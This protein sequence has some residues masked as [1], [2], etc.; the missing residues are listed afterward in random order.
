MKIYYSEW[1]RC[2][3]NEEGTG[4]SFLHSS[5]WSVWLSAKSAKIILVPFSCRYYLFA[6]WQ[7]V[8]KPIKNQN[9]RAWSWVIIH[10]FKTWKE[11]GGQLSACKTP[12]QRLPISTEDQSDVAWEAT[13]N[14]QRGLWGDRNVKADDS[15]SFH[16]TLRKQEFYTRWQSPR[17][18]SMH[19]YTM[20]FSQDLWDQDLF[21]QIDFFG[22]GGGVFV[23]NFHFLVIRIFPCHV[24]MQLQQ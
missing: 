23:F 24:R 12:R 1:L 22:G 8:G 2:Q 10:L 7:H 6:G 3:P 9:P 16:L 4:I 11:L 18:W 14:K 5:R 20:R 13:E 21:L 19:R 17:R 15:S